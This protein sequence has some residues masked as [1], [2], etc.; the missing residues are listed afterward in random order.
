MQ[1]ILKAKDRILAQLG[2]EVIPTPIDKIDWND[3]INRATRYTLPFEE[4]REKGFKDYVIAE[5]AV[6][7]FLSAKNGRFCMF[8]C[9]DKKMTTYLHERTI[10]LPRF[11]LFDSVP[12]LITDIELRLDEST[13]KIAGVL[14]QEAAQGFCGEG[15]EKSL[16][17]FETFQKQADA[18]VKKMLASE[19]FTKRYP[20]YKIAH[21]GRSKSIQIAKP[22]FINRPNRKTFRWQSVVTLEVDLELAEPVEVFSSKNL[23]LK[24]EFTVDWSASFTKK[25]EINPQSMQV[26]MF[27]ISSYD[28][29]LLVARSVDEYENIS[30][31]KK[32]AKLNV[33]VAN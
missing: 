31:D 16:F 17:T 27:R 25:G 3:A 10:D 5:T 12:A 26:E 7:H 9:D 13:R 24:A 28:M 8:V 29:Q 30:S 23:L 20:A 19:E 15:G 11:L 21:Q 1:E 14:L 22:I 33:F 4:A 18:E 2:I 32:L 6:Q